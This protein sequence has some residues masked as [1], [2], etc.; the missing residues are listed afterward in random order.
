METSRHDYE[1]LWTRLPSRARERG[2]S[3][4]ELAEGS[5]VYQLDILWDDRPAILLYADPAALGRGRLERVTLLLSNAA[6]QTDGGVVLASQSDASGT[7]LALCDSARTIANRRTS[8]TADAQ[9]GRG[10]SRACLAALNGALDVLEALGD[11]GEAAPAGIDWIAQDECGRWVLNPIDPGLWRTDT[12]RTWQRAAYEVAWAI[13]LGHAPTLGDPAADRAITDCPA[14]LS[15]CLLRLAGHDGDAIVSIGQARLVLRNTRDRRR[16]SKLLVAGVAVV[17]IAVAAVAWLDSRTVAM[18]KSIAA[19]TEG[20]V[21]ERRDALSSLA[22]NHPFLIFGRWTVSGLRAELDDQ[23]AKTIATWRKDAESILAAQPN[24]TAEYA[25]RLDALI[26][27]ATPFKHEVAE[28]EAPLLRRRAAARAEIVLASS[29]PAAAAIVEAAREL[30]A[31]GTYSAELLKRLRSAFDE[32]RWKSVAAPP[33]PQATT[34]ET[35]QFIEQLDRY[36]E[37]VPEDADFAGK[38][39]AY[40]TEAQRLRTEVLARR[41]QIQLRE[42]DKLIDEGK[43]AGNLVVAASRIIQLRRELIQSDSM[44]ASLKARASDLSVS[45]ALKLEGTSRAQMPLADRAKSLLD[46]EKIVRDDPDVFPPAVI[47]EMAKRIA[48]SFV[49]DSY[50]AKRASEL[51]PKGPTVQQALGLVGGTLQEDLLRAHACFEE[52]LRSEGTFSAWNRHLQ[53]E[54]EVAK[55]A[56]SLGLKGGRQIIRLSVR[57]VRITLLASVDDHFG[58]DWI[59]QIDGKGELGFDGNWQQVPADIASQITYPLQVHQGDYLFVP[60]GHEISLD[61]WDD[62]WGDDQILF[63]GYLILTDSGF[64]VRTVQGSAAAIRV[65]LL[66]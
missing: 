6:G 62:N 18:A 42:L 14:W 16:L 17:T 32:A 4:V 47:Q 40:A 64:R 46:W 15:A 24:N 3:A 1:Q 5:G 11:D 48:S 53:G 28:I 31:N 29:Q 41:E 63:S 12:G 7:W 27:R 9:A 55:H 61:I 30:R 2:S 60:K 10:T 20:T 58:N 65:E 54:W 66:P 26:S 25:N 44:R 49:L 37:D 59:A 35:N 33:G 34:H 43:R 56:E 52:W 36:L 57:A 13:S 39:R 21:F 19:R 8:V 51:P 23:C 38:F 22:D 45:Q 50:N